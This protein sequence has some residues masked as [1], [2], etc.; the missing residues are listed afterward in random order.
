MKTGNQVCHL[1]VKY[2]SLSDL[3]SSWDLIH[4]L[5]FLVTR[6]ESR[7]LGFFL[8][9]KQ[10]TIVEIILSDVLWCRY[11]SL[12]PWKQ[13]KQDK[14]YK[15]KQLKCSSG[16]NCIVLSPFLYPGSLTFFKHSED[17]LFHLASV[18]LQ[19]LFTTD[20]VTPTNSCQMGFRSRFHKETLVNSYKFLTRELKSFSSWNRVIFEQG[21]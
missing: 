11:T 2:R 4:A 18:H 10:M 8:A 19:T 9:L 12:K 3:S 7:Y 13:H 17:Q 20:I 21:C 14:V 1:S 5:F 16:Y 15:Y 6:N